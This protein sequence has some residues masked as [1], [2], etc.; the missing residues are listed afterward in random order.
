MIRILYYYLREPHPLTPSPQEVGCVPR[1]A[2]APYKLLLLCRCSN[3]IPESQ[4]RVDGSTGWRIRDEWLN[5]DNL[6]SHRQ[7]PAGYLKRAGAG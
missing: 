6:T 1:S 2:N 3:D 4:E 5:D 7:Q